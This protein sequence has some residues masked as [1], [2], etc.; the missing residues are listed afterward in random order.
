MTDF[1][2]EARD[3]RTADPNRPG[4]PIVEQPS[5]DGGFLYVPGEFLVSPAAAD[6]LP[7]LLDPEYTELTD[8]SP[9]LSAMGVRWFAYSGPAPL[10][11]RIATLQSDAQAAAAGSGVDPDACRVTPHLV[12]SGETWIYRGGPFDEPRPAEP[13]LSGPLTVPAAGPH[14][15]VLDTGIPTEAPGGLYAALHI[16]PQKDVDQMWPPGEHGPDFAAEAG[17]G[18]F[19][20]GIVSRMT[21]GM[22]GVTAL[23]VL[24]S[25]GYGTEQMVVDGL[26]RLRAAHPSVGVINLSLGTHTG[27]DLP[28]LG[29]SEALALWP[30]RTVVVAAAGNGGIAGRPYWPAA[31]NG[32]VAVAAIGWDGG[33]PVRPKFSNSG[34]WVDVC[35]DGVD[36]LSLHGFGHVPQGGGAY[37][38]IEG[39]VRWSGTSFAAPLVAA[40]IARR[41]VEQ[42]LS[43]PA[44]LES[45]LEGL[46]PAADSS[47]DFAGFGLLYD[48]RQFVGTDPTAP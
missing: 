10:L 43:A 29:V 47:P 23:R 20:V 35:T 7:V 4:F 18:M 24:D 44:A 41:M 17:H 5:D 3:A 1:W 46:R 45:L 32:V 36:V 11:D 19:I 27:D 33:R 38:Q 25:D 48:P 15:A 2:R 13:W 16:D 22:A 26:H 14:V 8:S 30:P 42:N 31:I 9:G 12:L 37:E 21:Y 28:P 39:W 40:E 34:S 6:L